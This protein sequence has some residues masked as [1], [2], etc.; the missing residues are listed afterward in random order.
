MINE[1]NQTNTIPNANGSTVPDAVSSVNRVVQGAHQAI[2][3]FAKFERQPH[4]CLRPNF[5]PAGRNI[6][7]GCAQGVIGSS[8]CLRNLRIRATHQ[9]GHAQDLN[10][11]FQLNQMGAQLALPWLRLRH[12]RQ[13][14]SDDRVQVRDRF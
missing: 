6:G 7:V 3:P 14:R 4:G 9:Q 10:L 2:N 13:Q 1:I 11:A 12:S 5:G 8:C